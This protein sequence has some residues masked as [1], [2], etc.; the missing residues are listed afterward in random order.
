MDSC[1]AVKIKV[2]FD[3]MLDILSSQTVLM[4]ICDSDTNI[5]YDLC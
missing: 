1:D 2:Q 4:V 3:G 5:I